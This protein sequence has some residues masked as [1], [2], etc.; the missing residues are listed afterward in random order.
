[1]VSASAAGCGGSSPGGRPADG[2]A[3]LQPETSVKLPA[4]DACSP[5][6]MGGGG[7][8]PLN[9]CGQ[10]K[11]AELLGPGEV[12]T[13]GADVLC[14]PPYVC[15]PDV[16]VAGGTALQLRCVMPQAGA[17]AFG[18]ACATGGAAGARCA[19]DELCIE[20]STAPG[21]PFCTALCRTDADCPAA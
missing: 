16:P 8:C 6:A 18:A 3:D 1:L 7:S 9:F 15:V 10:V 19:D 17:A 5:D 12:A 14:T 11:A 2:G 13:T 20:T 4:P 21:A